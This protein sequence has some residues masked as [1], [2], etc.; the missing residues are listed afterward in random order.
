MFNKVSII[1]QLGDLSEAINHQ[2][3]MVLVSQGADQLYALVSYASA[4][5]VTLTTV[6]SGGG[7]TRLYFYRRVGSNNNWR[8]FSLIDPQ[9]LPA[10][11]GD[12]TTRFKG[13]HPWLT[14]G[15]SAG[16]TLVDGS[17]GEVRVDQHPLVLP[18]EVV[19]T[20]TFRWYRVH[21]CGSSLLRRTHLEQEIETA[22]LR[23]RYRLT[24]S[25]SYEHFFFVRDGHSLCWRRVGAGK[26]RQL[27]GSRGF[28][29][30]LTVAFRLT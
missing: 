8:P 11:V 19:V 24:S 28:I 27:V 15:L 5:L 29:A 2:G 14:A 6:L 30:S 25:R 16:V 4:Q 17:T 10:L 1:P 12:Y 26:L 21:R 22:E 7:C 13:K 3:E 23:H 20:P 9:V 18:E